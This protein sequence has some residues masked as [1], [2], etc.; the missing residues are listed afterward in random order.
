MWTKPYGSTG[1]DISV[2]GFGGMRFDNPEDIDANAEVVLHAYKR[3]INYFDTAPGYCKDKSEDIV[4]AAVAH[5]TPGT[6]Y[7]SSKSMASDAA[8]FRKD[9]EKSLKR[10]GV[11]KLHFHHIWCLVTLDQWKKRQDGGAVAEALKA[12]EEGLVEHVVV[13]SHLIGDELKVVLDEGPFEGVTLGYCAINFPFR[14]VAVQAAAEKNMGVVTMN[15]LGGGMIPQNAER[16]DF[17]REPEDPSV[18]SAAIRFN[19]SHPDITCALVGCTTTEHVDEAVEAVEDFQP[20][21]Q[22]HVERIREKLLGSFEGL[23]TG[24]G[25]CLPCPLGVEIPKMMDAYN[26]RILQGREE[27]HITDRLKYHW[28]LSPE[29]A[30]ACSLCGACEKKCTQH[31]PIR[32]RLKEI[33]AIAGG[34]LEKQQEEKKEKS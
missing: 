25:Y 33:A 5:M 1:K 34:D 22:E 8:G 14:E 4:G 9:L 30:L 13:S 28:A 27:R 17:L 11:E 26:M 16:F 19:V 21:P 12:K 7:L 10:L 24:C 20:Y 32:E 18:V 3:G 23:C 6:F 31:I 29:D 15:P 2:V